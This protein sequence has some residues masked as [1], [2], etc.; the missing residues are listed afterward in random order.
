M[1]VSIVE[2]SIEKLY[3]GK[4]NV[5]TDMGD[6]TE[7]TASIKEKGILQPILARPAGEKH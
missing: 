3:V 2:I 4:C 5:R 1:K 6:V 7:L